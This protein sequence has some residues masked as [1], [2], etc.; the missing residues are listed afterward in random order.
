MPCKEFDMRHDKYTILYEKDGTTYTICK[1]LFG[2]DGSYFV[3]SPYHPSKQAVLLK[4]TVNYALQKM[5][6]AFDQLVDTASVDDERRIKLS[7][8]RS[9]LVQFSGEGI[10][11]GIDS[12]GNIRGIGVRSWPLDKPVQGPAFGITIIGVD[13]FQQVSQMEGDACLFKHE[14]VIPAPRA[15]L[16]MLEGYYF[17]PL[18]R[19]FVRKEYDRSHTISIVHPAGVALKLKVLFAPESCALPG[20]IGLEMYTY[21]GDFGATASGFILAGST[22]HIRKNEKGETLGDGIWC[23]Y[24]RLDVPMHRSVDYMDK[25]FPAAS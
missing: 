24:P 5:D 25:E 9:G 10:L 3:T 17:P 2:S 18:W 8:H 14:E 6:I 1:V 16:L 20:F 21:I 12:A 22:G 13:E 23:M 11:S 15:N 7:H 4:A 19:R